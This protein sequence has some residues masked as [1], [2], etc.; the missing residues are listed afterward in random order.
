MNDFADFIDLACDRLGGEVLA[1]SDEFFA[2]KEN[3]IKIG[4]SV[5]EPGRYTEQGKWMDGWETRR[6]RGPGH[7]WCI[8]KLATPGQIHGIVIDTSHFRGNHPETAALDA[9][10]LDTDALPEDWTTADIPWT[11]L[12][13]DSQI[14]GDSKHAFRVEHDD[15]FTH[16]RLRIHP[17]GGVARLRIYGQVRPDW[18]ILRLAD[19]IDLAAALNGGR[20]C[21]CSDACF[22]HPENLLLP[23]PGVHMGEGWE[24]RRRRGEG[25]D[26]CIVQLGARG[27]IETVEVDTRHFKG[28]YPHCFNLEVSDGQTNWIE[29]LPQTELQADHVQLFELVDAPPCTHARFNIYPDGGV[30]RLR[31]YGRPA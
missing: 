10:S 5:F 9:C 12:L 20:I 3:L 7:D 15:C 25:H 23:D 29:L 31:L 26:W 4:S 8:V 22:S 28:N 19:R 27:I 13:G 17:D 6:R 24:T 1:A 2:P 18:N 21:D 11:N 14:D 16:V 30:G